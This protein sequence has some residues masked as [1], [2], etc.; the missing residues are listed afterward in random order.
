MHTKQKTQLISCITYCDGSGWSEHNY[1]LPVKHWYQ[2]NGLTLPKTDAK[3][4]VIQPKQQNNLQ[5]PTQA[6][7]NR[8][9]GRIFVGKWTQFLRVYHCLLLI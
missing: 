3:A 5:E 7:I 6:I 2:S 8:R 1:L 4:I 9:K